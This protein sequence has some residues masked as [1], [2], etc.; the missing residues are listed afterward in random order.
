ME[1]FII[2]DDNI[3]DEDLTDSFDEDVFGESTLEDEDF[4][5]D[6]NYDEWN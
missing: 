6:Y 1:S 2:P 3:F 5:S 4:S